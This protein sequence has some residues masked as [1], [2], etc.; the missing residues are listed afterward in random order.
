MRTAKTIRARRLGLDLLSDNF[1]GQ[2]GPSPALAAFAPP[3]EHWKQCLKQVV[4]KDMFSAEDS[5]TRSVELSPESLAHSPRNPEQTIE[6]H[7][8]LSLERSSGRPKRSLRDF[9]PR[10]VMKKT[11]MSGRAFCGIVDGYTV[12]GVLDV[13]GVS[14]RNDRSVCTC[15]SIETLSPGFVSTLQVEIRWEREGRLSFLAARNGLNSQHDQRT[16]STSTNSRERRAWSKKFQTS[17]HQHT[18]FQSLNPNLP[19]HPP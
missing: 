14:A 19:P 8:P 1:C 9:T 17:Y 13:L 2:H 10:T 11:L 6:L 4:K 18:S 15:G 5:T 7:T 3:A 12:P 16:T